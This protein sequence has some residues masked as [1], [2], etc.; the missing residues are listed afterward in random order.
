MFSFG[1]GVVSWSNKKQPAIALSSIEVEYRGATIV[2][3]EIIWLQKLLIDL[4][5]LV[6]AHV[7][8][9]CDNISSILLVNNPVYHVK[10]EHIEVHYH[11]ISSSK[12][13]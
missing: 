12:R 6:D 3:C 10:T 7:V 1:S 9:Y 5:Q 4:G 13:N 2:T 8:I 11:F